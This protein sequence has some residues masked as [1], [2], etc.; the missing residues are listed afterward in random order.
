MSYTVVL[1]TA[2][3]AGEGKKIGR[4]LLAKKLAACVS[5]V[6]GVASSYWWKGKI[7]RSLE[8]LLIIKTHSSKLPRLIAEVKKNHSY[9]VPEV[10]ALPVIKGNPDYLTWVGKSLK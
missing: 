8:N 4:L 7:E 1:I 5:R 3:S 2:P 10:I 6:P 9:A